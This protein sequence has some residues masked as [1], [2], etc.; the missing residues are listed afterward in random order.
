MAISKKLKL[1]Q[2]ILLE[3]TYDD[4]NIKNENYHIISNLNDG[5][6]YFT[7]ESTLNKIE[8]TLFT[9]DDVLKRQTQF[10]F[11][12]FNFLRK[13][14]YGS[15]PIPYDKAKIYLPIDFN[16]PNYI[17]FNI[18]IYTYDY[19][20]NNF[21]VLS[22]F[23]YDKSKHNEFSYIDLERPFVY[24][25]TTWGKS[26]T[27]N[28]PSIYH[29]SKDRT[30]SY[31]KNIVI[32]N[33]IND[34]LTNGIGLSQTAPIFID[35]SFISSIEN[36][37][38]VDYYTLSDTYETSI[39]QQPEYQSLGVEVKESEQ[40]DFFEIYGV[41][42]GT[43]ELI[44][45]F[46]EELTAKG[47]RIE[48]EYEVRLFE[49][50]LQSGNIQRFRVEDNFS[51]KILYRP[52][53]QYSNTTASIDVQMNIIDLI[54]NS[55]IERFSSVGLTKNLFKYGKRL[56]K[57]NLNENVVK[58]KIYKAKPE[59][60]I[61]NGGGDVTEIKLTKVP[62]PV[63]V[64][65]YK[66]LI[67]STNSIN[68]DYKSNGL[69]NIVITPFD[70]VIKFDLAK[71]IDEEGE[72]TPYNLSEISNNA[73]LKLIFKTESKSVEKSYYAQSDDNDFEN[74]VIIYKINESDIKTIK[75]I[76][77]EGNKNF[78]LTL[79]GNNNRTLLYSGKYEFYEN[80]KF[81]DLQNINQKQEDKSKQT[82]QYK[83][84]IDR[85]KEKMNN[86]KIDK[87]ER[88]NSR[89]LRRNTPFRKPTELLKDNKSYYNLLTFI[90]KN[91]NRSDFESEL[92][93]MG[94]KNWINK[95]NVYYLSGIHILRVQEIEKLTKYVDDV[96][97]I[98]IYD[99]QN[100]PKKITPSI[101]NELVEKAI[102]DKSNE[103]RSDQVTVR[104]YVR[105]DT[106]TEINFED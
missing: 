67:N 62:F 105:T 31:D 58:P 99:G 38:G 76:Y 8:N 72:P 39:P 79:V 26:I 4:N 51:Q 66:I 65:K 93:Q 20:N 75:Q 46:V 87:R 68:D 47:R 37:L 44:N 61:M 81:V 28:I 91:I 85:L 71:S 27:I 80:V 7:S 86:I 89:F 45:N 40:G 103:I 30:I 34:H 59:R 15:S 41:Y 48:I 21:Y 90:K 42:K 64:D 56:N 73:E 52:I 32:S 49:E 102:K 23:F 16:F 12:R 17:G 2:N 92:N 98:N 43:N 69:L 5:T 29:I 6:R 1:N 22:N 50:G 36:V 95:D 96:I 25:E 11:D 9:I 83:N 82:E 88:D 74:G 94:I 106:Q 77:N 13:Q 101:T 100:Q 78:Y 10:N 57:I 24:D 53:I 33:T 55:Q 19:E 60:I 3:Y 54:N 35:F 97:K 84:E 70:N 18:K 104:P 63:L 14:S